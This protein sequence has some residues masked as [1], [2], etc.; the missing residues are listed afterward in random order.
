MHII[1]RLL[2]SFSLNLVTLF[3]LFIL[4]CGVAQAR[5]AS[6][7][8]TIIKQIEDTLL[9]NRDAKDEIGL[10][11]KIKKKIRKSD[12]TIN[13]SGKGSKGFSSKS[14]SVVMKVKDKRISNMAVRKKERM[15][16]N[17]SIS[18]Q[19]EVAIALYKEVLKHE[20]RN[21]YARFSLAILYQKI[22]QLSQAKEIYYKILKSDPD[23][24]EEIISNLLSIMIEESPRDAVYVLARLLTQNPESSYIYAQSAIAYDKLNDHE[25]AIRML[26]RAIILAPNKVDYQYN[27]AVIYDKKGD[28]RE[29]LGRYSNALKGLDSNDESQ[30]AFINQIQSRIQSLKSIL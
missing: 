19:Y 30:I 27:L 11:N 4:V 13:R 8:E 5:D 14:S 15:A 29:A 23:N 3:F 1:K 25:N 6:L 17:A 24:K 9:F 12:I 20:P 2:K 28:Y 16:Y 10:H 22:G 18:E 21:D 26:K 7:N